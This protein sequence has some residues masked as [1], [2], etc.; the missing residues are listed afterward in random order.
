MAQ[1]V[2]R[3]HGG[4]GTIGGTI[5][6][7][8]HGGHRLVFDLGRPFD[9][10][11]PVFDAVLTARGV[12][13]LQAMR[14]APRIPGLLTGD[15]ADPEGAQTLVAISH[16]HPD[17]TS[18]LPYLRP[19]IPVLMHTESARLMDLLADAGQGPGRH[20]ARLTAKSGEIVTFGPFRITLLP[21]D[22]D[23]PGACGLL[24]E[25]PDLRAVYT[26]DLRL[27]GCRPEQT[28]QFADAA[29]AFGPDVLWIEGTRANEAADA[30]NIP[31]PDIA[32]RIAA[33]LR[34]ARHGAY[35]TYYPWNPDR[36]RAMF[37]AARTAGRSVVV[38]PEDLYL[39]AHLTGDLPE[40]LIWWPAED[41][42]EPVRAWL[43]EMQL[44]AVRPEAVRRREKDLLISMPYH[45]FIRFIDIEPEPGGIYMHSN[46]YPL[47]P[48]DPAWTNFR[49]W[50]DAFRLQL[51]SVSSSGHASREEVIALA[52][53][54][55]PRLLMPI[56]SLAPER[57]DSP[58]LARVL[59][60][61]GVAYSVADIPAGGTS[62]S[63]VRRS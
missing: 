43:R 57:I 40:C 35:F 60:E 7:M 33:V 39:Y 20:P 61:Y 52:E 49:H 27:H 11:R 56:H 48:F 58:R 45:R 2:W 19:D 8:R 34:E 6:E 4:V 59:P 3:F 25:T 32:D 63:A 53:R 21:V 51:V 29:C 9:P 12:R 30:E 16:L 44:P 42:T 26:G 50:L 47:G 14:C 23:I 13:D 46:G 28:L 5:I 22:H 15:E 1:T 37:T 38:E 54:M 17:H 18:L 24:I 41:T 55:A 62:T 31:E 36:L 10:A